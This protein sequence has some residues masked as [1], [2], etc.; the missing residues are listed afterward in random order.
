MTLAIQKAIGHRC[1]FHSTSFRDGEVGT[2]PV[3]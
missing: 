3:R 2:V 1:T